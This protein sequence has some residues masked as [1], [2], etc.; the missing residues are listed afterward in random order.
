MPNQTRRISVRLSPCRPLVP[1]YPCTPLVELLTD[2]FSAAADIREETELEEAMLLSQSPYVNGEEEIPVNKVHYVYDA[3]EE[4]AKQLAAEEAAE[5]AGLAAVKTRR[6][7]DKQP[8]PQPTRMG[9][10]QSSG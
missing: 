2:A 7:L 6:S 9:S 10:N 4:R 5:L 8:Q 3:A 1:L